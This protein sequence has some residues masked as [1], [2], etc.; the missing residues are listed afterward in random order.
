MPALAAFGNWNVTIQVEAVTQD[1]DNCTVAV[2]IQN[3]TRWLRIYYQLS[4]QNEGCVARTEIYI[5]VHQ[6]TKAAAPWT[7]TSLHSANL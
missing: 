1:S 5:F 2:S 4:L 6:K 3:I 7:N